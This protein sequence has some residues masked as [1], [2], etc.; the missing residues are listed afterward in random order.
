MPTMKILF[1]QANLSIKK[2]F[3]IQ[4]IIFK[5]N[6]KIFVRKITLNDDAFSHLNG[7]KNN[8][9][10][11][12]KNKINTPK[13]IAKKINYIDFE[14][15]SFP[16]LEYFIE[17]KIYEQ[18]FESLNDLIKIGFDFINSLKTIK[19]NPY[20]NKEFTEIFDPKN[21]I[22]QEV[23][24]CLNLG[25]LD[26]NFDNLLFDSKKNKIYLID[27][28]WFFNF[29]IPKKLILF[30]SIFYLSLHLQSLI[31]NRCS[32]KFPCLE[33]FKN[34]YVPK[35]F[36]Q[37]L[38]FKPDEIKKYYFWEIN[39]QNYVNQMQ[40]K[41]DENIFVEQFNEKKEKLDNSLYKFS[42]S[43]LDQLTQLQSQ[44]QK[45]LFQIQNLEA[46]I[47]QLQ[48]HNRNLETQ[49]NTIKSAKFFRLWQ[50]YCKIRDKILKRKI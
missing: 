10:V 42:F 22:K 35:I 5:E 1:A 40:I 23:E 8:Y 15:L 6:K 29:P 37:N 11:I 16:S 21:L 32:P 30:R 3:Q 41:Y 28:E 24:E 38:N 9:L 36:W 31:K 27:F 25:I 12:K 13:I 4:T 47:K 50:S 34:F 26:I 2:P 14:F 18:D 20:Q 33:I 45:Q 19:I 39:F 48:N 43:Q 17:E 44:P 49:L 46:Q 7:L